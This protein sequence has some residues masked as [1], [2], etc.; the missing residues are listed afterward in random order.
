MHLPDLSSSLHKGLEQRDVPTMLSLYDDDAELDIVD[1]NHTPSHPLRLKGK[2]EL[3]QYFNDVLNRP[4][5]HHIEDEVM[6]GDHLA[7]TD[8]CEYPDGSKV[9]TS[10][11]ATLKDSKIVHEVDS[12]AWDG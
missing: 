2:K 9:F 12:Q 4:L 3:E 1:R 6:A 11:M 8:T 5:T 7:Y 10:A